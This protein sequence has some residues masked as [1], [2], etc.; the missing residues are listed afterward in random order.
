MNTAI[1]I[2]GTYGAAHRGDDNTA[3]D[4]MIACAPSTLLPKLIPTTDGICEP[5]RPSERIAHAMRNPALTPKQFGRLGE[6]YVA[7]VFEERG[8]RTLSTNWRTRYG[9]IDIVM[10]SPEHMVVFIEVKSRRCGQMSLFGLPQ[11]AVTTTKQRN[12]RRACTAWLLDR[13]NRIAHRGI[14]FDVATVVLESDRPTMHH[15]PGAF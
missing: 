6:R 11:E 9:E 10:L 8:W 14:R 1:D 15:I 13:R 3:C 4:D 7:A 5:S 2:H 12:L